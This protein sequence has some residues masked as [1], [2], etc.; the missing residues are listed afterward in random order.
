MFPCCLYIIDYM[1]ID[2]AASES[3][4]WKDGT[5]GILCQFVLSILGTL[6]VHL[7]SEEICFHC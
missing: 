4:T 6:A 5:Y 3:S 2:I 7:H 1:I